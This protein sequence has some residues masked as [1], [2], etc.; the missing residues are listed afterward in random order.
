MTQKTPET[1]LIARRIAAH[2]NGA[3]PPPPLAKYRIMSDTRIITMALRDTPLFHVQFDLNDDH[4][5]TANRL[6]PDGPEE[7]RGLGLQTAARD[8]VRLLIQEVCTMTSAPRRLTASTIS[9]LC[10]RDPHHPAKT[11]VYSRAL[12][13]E[14]TLQARLVQSETPIEILQ[15]LRLPLDLD[16]YNAL[17][18][19][20]HWLPQAMDNLTPEITAYFRDIVAGP[21]RGRPYPQSTSHLLARLKA[22][23]TPSPE[24]QIAPE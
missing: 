1:S 20:R 4:T 2:L 5:L 16:N 8:T 14:E 7:I 9:Q 24:Q 10:G 6:M 22:S 17:T 12:Q 19:C 13:I 18:A 21:T 15:Q 3:G 23:E 11:R